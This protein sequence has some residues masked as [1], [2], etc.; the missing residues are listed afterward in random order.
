MARIS[1]SAEFAV[2]AACVDLPDDSLSGCQKLGDHRAR[3]RAG[4]RHL[5]HY[6]DKL[7][8]QRSLEAGVAA[9]YFQVGIAN[10]RKRDAHQGLAAG[11]GSRHV[12][13]RNVLI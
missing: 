13:N 11:G 7:M 1:G 3:W 5:F 12:F 10:S 4:F 9:R 2:P 8:A 6:A